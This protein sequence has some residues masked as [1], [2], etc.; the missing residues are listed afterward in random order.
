MGVPAPAAVEIAVGGA[1]VTSTQDS[2]EARAEALLE[3]LRRVVPFQ[4]AR[5]SLFDPEQ[6]ENLTLISRGFPA[7]VNSPAVDEVELVGLNR[8]GPPLRLR[9]LPMPH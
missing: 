6:Y 1:G 8:S 4:A 9:D 3:P 7:G 2:V 5:I